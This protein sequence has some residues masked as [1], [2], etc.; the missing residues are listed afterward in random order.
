[1]T[2][3]AHHPTRSSSL[4]AEVERVSAVTQTNCLQFIACRH[5]CWESS[6]PIHYH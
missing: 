5:S 3:L 4:L 6:W 1:M 2:N